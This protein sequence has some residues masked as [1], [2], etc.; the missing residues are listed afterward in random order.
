MMNLSFLL[1]IKEEEYDDTNLVHWLIKDLNV[2]PDEE[3]EHDSCVCLDYNKYLKEKSIVVL[4]E[5]NSK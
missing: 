4:K 3:D 2:K 1:P 5:R